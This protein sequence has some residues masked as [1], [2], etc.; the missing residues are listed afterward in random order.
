MPEYLAP[1]V[2]VEETEV[3]ATPIEAVDMSTAVMIGITG[4]DPIEGLRESV[5]TFVDFERK[6]EMS[7][8]KEV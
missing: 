1:G 8:E 2:Y 3:G 4:N 6:F 7:L 5:T